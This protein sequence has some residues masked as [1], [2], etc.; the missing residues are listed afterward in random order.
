MQVGRYG[1]P[2]TNTPC[3][4]PIAS[5]PSTNIS[6]RVAAFSGY[7]PSPAP[8]VP[9]DSRAAM[10]ITKVDPTH[11]TAKT[12]RPSSQVAQEDQR[13]P[14]ICNAPS[15]SSS[16]PKPV[17]SP[18]KPVAPTAMR[19][20]AGHNDPIPGPKP[21][22]LPLVPAPKVTSAF[23]PQISNTSAPKSSIIVEKGFHEI[24]AEDLRR[25][26]DLA[27]RHYPNLDFDNKD[28]VLAAYRLLLGDVRDPGVL[29][30]L[31]EAAISATNKAKYDL[32]IN[33]ASLIGD[34][35]SGFPG[36]R[37]AANAAVTGYGAAAHYAIQT[38]KPALCEEYESKARQMQLRRDSLPD[39]KKPAA[40]SSTSNTNARQPEPAPKVTAAP[41]SVVIDK[42]FEDCIQDLLRAHDRAR[43]SY[44]NLNFDSKDEVLAA[45]RLLIGPERSS[46]VFILLGEAATAAASKTKY[47]L[48]TNYADL[49][50]NYYAGFPED[51]GAANAAVI[52]YGAAAHYATQIPKPALC[53]EY[54]SKSR[55]MQ[56]RRDS[57]PDV[58]KPT[59]VSST[60]NTNARQPEPAP[61]V[62]A[63]VNQVAQ[64]PL[65]QP[66]VPQS[67]P[68]DVRPPLAP[69]AV[70]AQIQGTPV[71]PK[72]TRPA[73]YERYTDAQFAKIAGPW[74][75]EQ[76]KKMLPNP[77][78]DLNYSES[79][80]VLDRY[81]YFM[82]LGN[83]GNANNVLARGLDY[84]LN[85]KDRE[86]WLCY[87]ESLAKHQYVYNNRS[88]YNTAIDIYNDIINGFFPAGT[89]GR[90]KYVRLG[91]EAVAKRDQCPVQFPGQT[92]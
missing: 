11:G 92:L 55:Q 35:Y 58:K 8:A 84:A 46:T 21:K 10:P 30:L 89:P 26:H 6:S 70:A 38:S 25:G 36:D 88:G 78:E 28:K 90:E 86:L 48:A 20:L 33:Y 91:L 72:V 7:T 71:A 80:S 76:A 73:G 43:Q 68:V 54:K 83:F 85:R 19:P 63:A 49:I 1:P 59:A 37:Q 40:V 61:K 5:Q 66:P 69:R 22:P 50:G 17:V 65:N 15:N 27:R 75:Q 2:K 52:G 47:D 42:C 56:L 39:V 57:L 14:F 31:G 45:Y 67:T 3:T 16:P 12:L 81:R 77:G 18:A 9:R 32:A 41:K 29:I 74:T 23:V 87:A 51:K 44:P 13:S 60:S 79:N 4:P 82:S 62:T 24:C 53:E 64:R 34:Y